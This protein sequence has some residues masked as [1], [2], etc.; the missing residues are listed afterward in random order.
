MGYAIVVSPCYCCEAPF[1]YNPHRVPS[2]PIGPNGQPS[3]TGDR[4]PLCRRCVEALNP[5][6][7][8]RGLD[9]IVIY[10]D[11]YEPVPDAD[12]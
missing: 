2:I 8:A 1:G 4:K 5:V 12:L 3:P 7:V 11:S 9:P 6:R 10:P